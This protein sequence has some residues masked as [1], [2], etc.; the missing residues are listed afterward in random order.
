MCEELSVEA[1]LN[2]LNDNV[3]L[4]EKLEQLGVV[5]DDNGMSV[6]LKYSDLLTEEE[7]IFLKKVTEDFNAKN[8]GDRKWHIKFGF[9]P[10]VR[11][12]CESDIICEKCYESL[13]DI[14]K[15]D[16]YIR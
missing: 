2:I 8:E 12:M 16:D 3:A 14:R 7:K 6:P 1:Y 5:W 4:K 13:Q 10:G 11:T 15:H 9:A